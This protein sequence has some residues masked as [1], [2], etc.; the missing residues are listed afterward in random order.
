MKLKI[1]RNVSLPPRNM[2]PGKGFTYAVRKLKPGDSVLLP[3]SSQA[4]QTI[5]KQIGGRFGDYGD[6]S[7]SLRALRAAGISG[8]YAARREGSGTRIYRRK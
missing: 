4:A 3:T 5:V 7:E 1:E 6:L 2:N 8:W